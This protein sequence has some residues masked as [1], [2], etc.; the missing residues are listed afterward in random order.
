V[1]GDE[2]DKVLQHDRTTWNEG[3]STAE[4]DDG[5]GWE[6]TEGGSWRWLHFWRRRHASG[7]R[8]WTGGKG[9]GGGELAL[10]SCL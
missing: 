1:A 8:L 10:T 4:G 3:R 6:L 5:R 2:G 9:A 7:G